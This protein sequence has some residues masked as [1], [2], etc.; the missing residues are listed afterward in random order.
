MIAAKPVQEIAP[1][2]AKR[3]RPRQH[4][5][6]AAKQAAY[7]DRIVSKAQDS[8]RRTLLAKILKRVRASLPTSN[9]QFGDAVKKSNRERIGRLHIEL[10]QLSV[11]ALKTYR[12]T[13]DRT[14]DHTG[15]MWGERSGEADRQHGQSEIEQI[16]SRR[17]HDVSLGEA[18]EQDPLLSGGYQV[19][20]GGAGPGDEQNSQMVVT[21]PIS[22]TARDKAIKRIVLQ[23]DTN[24]DSMCLYCDE[25][26]ANMLAAERHLYEM[27]GKAEAETSKYRKYVSA[28]L[29]SKIDPAR[30][31][32]KG[33]I[34]TIAV[35]HDDRVMK[36]A[37][38][39]KH[40]IIVTDRIG[41]RR[42]P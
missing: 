21:S 2:P 13:L 4:V 5:D 28:V 26:F 3:G 34:V 33:Q 25:V 40:G 22:D 6:G 10:G 30:S 42:K 14:H 41:D 32:I 20:P 23:I 16:I 24:G 18:S 19:R 37:R 15:R 39:R 17:Q 36:Q 27:C 12:E 31:L 29:R 8:E 35:H 38:R 1:T 7:R 9:L 11:A